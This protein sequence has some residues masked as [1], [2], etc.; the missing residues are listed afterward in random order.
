MSATWSRGFFLGNQNDDVIYHLLLTRAISSPNFNF[1]VVYVDVK[2]PGRGYTPVC[3]VSN[4]SFSN[5]VCKVFISSERSVN[6]LWNFETLIKNSVKTLQPYAWNKKHIWIC[7][8]WLLVSR[9]YL[10]IYWDQLT[11]GIPI[12]K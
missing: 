4:F 12:D 3:K 11:L 9:Y 5:S 1:V 6:L 7:K 8:S 2:I 10:W